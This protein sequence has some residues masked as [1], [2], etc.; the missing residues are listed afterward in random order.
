MIPVEDYAAWTVEIAVRGAELDRLFSR[1]KAFSTR[2]T[3][4]RAVVDLSHARG[5]P[6]GDKLMQLRHLESALEQIE[7]ELVS[8][9][10]HLHAAVR[11]SAC[12]G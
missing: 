10:E 4:V 6:A 9:A 8:A 7:R 2:F 3:D 1:Y 5:L 11:A 12:D